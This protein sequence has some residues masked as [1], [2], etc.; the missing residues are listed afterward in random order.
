MKRGVLTLVSASALLVAGLPGHVY[1]QSA[2]AAPA[3][4]VVVVV[5]QKPGGAP[6]APAP[7]PNASAL[8]APTLTLD[9]PATANLGATLPI[10]AVLAAPDGQPV[11]GAAVDFSSSASFLNTTGKIVF[12]HAVTDSL[13][14]ASVEWQPRSG[15]SIK[16]DATYA[17]DQRFATA[18]T[19][20]AV[21]VKGDQQLYQQQAGVV[22]PG[23][24]AAPAFT[25]TAALAPVANP[26]PRI[27]GWPLVVVLLIVWSLY[28]RAVSCLFTIARGRESTPVGAKSR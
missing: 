19:T 5:Q 10:R 15:G 21:E 1:A 8:P 18:K 16:L 14:A 17:G 23:L 6:A 9:A 26:W 4:P 27:S 3:K 20:A 28:A 13:G 12:A 2:P 22:L 25:R 11:A 7:A 24:N